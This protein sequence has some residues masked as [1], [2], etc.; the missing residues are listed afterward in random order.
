MF[1]SSGAVCLTSLVNFVQPRVEKKPEVAETSNPGSSGE[2]AEEEEKEE[3]A[4]AP[5][6]RR[7][8]T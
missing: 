2:K 7:R 3:T 1:L 4:A 5:R 6:R 8:D